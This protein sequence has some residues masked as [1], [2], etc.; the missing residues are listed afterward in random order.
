MPSKSPKPQIDRVSPVAAIPGGE[1]QIMGKGLMSDATKPVVSLGEVEAR[2]VVGSDALL[3]ARVPDDASIGELT[4]TNNTGASPL[5]NCEIGIQIA[6][7]LHPVASPAVDEFGNIY[8]TFSGSR[9]QKTPVAVYKL[10]LNYSLKPFV[11]DLMNATSLAF[12]PAGVLHVSSRFDGIVYQVTGAG[13]LSVY[14]E[15]MGTATGIAFDPQGNLF[16]GDRSGTIFKVSPERQIYVYATLEPSIS[17]YHLA[18]DNEGN[19]FVTGPTTSSFDVIHKVAPDGTVTPFF[20][21]LGRPQGIALDDAGNLYCCA[22]LAGRR[23]VVK[24]TPEG[25]ADLAVSGPGMVGLAF[26]PSRAM[27][28]TTTN[29]LY[30]VDAGIKGRSLF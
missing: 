14:C 9:G 28:L 29:A 22:S 20:R 24:I 3:V 19:L 30:R 1:F 18:F 11:T 23:G 15:G 21:G 2:L 16:V 8:T 7:N 13:D 17:A 4:V 27:V 5:W 25:K 26:T 12:S 10:D 6:D